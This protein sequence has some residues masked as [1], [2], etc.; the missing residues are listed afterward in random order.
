MRRAAVL[1]LCLLATRALECSPVVRVRTEIRLPVSI[2]PNPAQ[3]HLTLALGTTT[4]PAPAPSTAPLTEHH[5]I[6]TT[7]HGFVSEIHIRGHRHWVQLTAWVDVNGNA[8]LDSGD[9]IGS[10]PSAVEASDR[11]LCAGNMNETPPIGLRV[12]P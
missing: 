8:V 6:E 4:L 12:V 7:R 5:V 2:T 10:L 9:Y 1:V 11:G 3:L